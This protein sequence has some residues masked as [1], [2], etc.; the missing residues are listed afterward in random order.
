LRNV[1]VEKWPSLVKVVLAAGA[2]IFAIIRWPEQEP[3]DLCQA[4]PALPWKPSIV[5]NCAAISAVCQFIGTL[6]S[7]AGFHPIELF[8]GKSW[9]RIC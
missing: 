3:F 8:E 2:V 9:T 5:R 6:T 7:Q 1:F 4:R